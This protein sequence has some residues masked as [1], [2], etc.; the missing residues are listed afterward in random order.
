MKFLWSFVADEKNLFGVCAALGYDFGF[1]P[2]YLR[3]VFAILLIWNP[4]VIVGAY[5]FTGFVVAVSHWLFPDRRGNRA[6]SGP[7]PA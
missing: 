6:L 1:N 3:L 5:V 2:L 7:V 4:P